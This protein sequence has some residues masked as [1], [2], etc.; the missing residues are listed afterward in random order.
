MWTDDGS[1]EQVWRCVLQF[2]MFAGLGSLLTRQLAK[3]TSWYTKGATNNID[4]VLIANA[5]LVHS[6]K[7]QDFVPQAFSLQNLLA[8]IHSSE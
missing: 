2:R 7:P 6:F 1:C 5:V 4:L 8:S 3:P